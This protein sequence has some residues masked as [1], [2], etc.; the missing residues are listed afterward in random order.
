MSKFIVGLN[1]KEIACLL[2]DFNIVFVYIHSLSEYMSN[3]FWTWY[4]YNYAAK[5][6]RNRF[7]NKQSDMRIVSLIH[8]YTSEYES[9]VIFFYFQ[10]KGE[11]F[12]ARNAVFRTQSRSFWFKSGKKNS[13]G[14]EEFLKKISH[15]SILFVFFDKSF[16]VE[17]I[18]MDDAL[19]KKFNGDDWNLKYTVT[20]FSTVHLWVTG[21]F[22]MNFLVGFEFLHMLPI[23][24]RCSSSPCVLYV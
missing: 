19:T 12:M 17:N 14:D 5:L 8:I 13:S 23:L 20:S 4:L 9:I 7:H 3:R 21:K 16:T 11:T 24:A 6:K 2:N 15:T 10:S 22:P 1:Y 18:T